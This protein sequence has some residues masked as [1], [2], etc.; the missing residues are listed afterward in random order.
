MLEIIIIINKGWLK[1]VYIRE[2]NN[3]KKGE[4]INP[5]INIP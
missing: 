3:N 1:Y 2:L 4:N 5:K